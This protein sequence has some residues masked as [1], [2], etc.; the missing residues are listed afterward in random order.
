MGDLL[1]VPSSYEYVGPV[2]SNFDHQIDEEIGQELREE[3]YCAGYAAWNF[4]GKVWFDRDSDQFAC[5]I[6]R[7]H[8]HIDTILAED[9]PALMEVVSEKYGRE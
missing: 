6:W 3:E 1:K 4:H 5:E 7:Y 8:V 2:M 9:L